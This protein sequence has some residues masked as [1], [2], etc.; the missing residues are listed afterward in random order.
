MSPYR[1]PPEACDHHEAVDDSPRRED[2]ILA[3]MLLVIGGVRL[4]E[5]I[6]NQEVF[7]AEATVALF[8]VAFACL[9]LLPTGRRG[10]RLPR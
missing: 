3:V 2:V 10:E 8:M 4:M 7:H 6:L 5:T 1:R 9:T